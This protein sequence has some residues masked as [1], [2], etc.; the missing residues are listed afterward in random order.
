MRRVS[1]WRP[2]RG[3][4]RGLDGW[5]MYLPVRVRHLRFRPS[6]CT[7]QPL[8]ASSALIR[9]RLERCAE[10]CDVGG[11]GKGGFEKRKTQSRRWL[12][13]LSFRPFT[14]EANSPPVE[15]LPSNLGGD[16][17]NHRRTWPKVWPSPRL[18]RPRATASSLH[19]AVW[20][21]RTYFVRSTWSRCRGHIISERGHDAMCRRVP[22]STARLC[23]GSRSRDAYVELSVTQSSRGLGR[24]PAV[25]A[26]LMFCR[27]GQCFPGCCLCAYA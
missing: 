17:A 26:S 9:S 6:P 22:P 20:S 5:L 21:F 7:V 19:V 10:R 14:F 2:L 11:S 25:S 23:P 8:G 13:R 1:A 27:N 18:V 24:Y 15:R 12:L 3:R 16:G 4:C